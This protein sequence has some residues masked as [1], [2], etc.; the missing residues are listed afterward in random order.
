[1]V[2]KDQ[3]QRKEQ[4]RIWESRYE[5]RYGASDAEHNGV[6]SENGMEG[7][8]KRTQITEDSLGYETVLMGYC[9]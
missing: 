6:F 8:L 3:E 9:R 1:M 5:L 7:L 4:E 2:I